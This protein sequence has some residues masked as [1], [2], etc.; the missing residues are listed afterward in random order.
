M[1]ILLLRTF[2]VTQRTSLLALAFAA[3]SLAALVVACNKVPLLAPTGRVIAPLPS[4]GD[5][6][7]TIV[8]T[9]IENGTAQS[10]SGLSGA[11]TRAAAGTPVQNGTLVTFTTTI[12]QIQP[13]EATTHNGQ[14]TVALVTGSACGTAHITAYSGGASTSVDLK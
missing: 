14:V 2:M 13:S 8:A 6:E 4:A 10:G 5:G 12:G 9:V 3:L 11:T 7:V 1:R